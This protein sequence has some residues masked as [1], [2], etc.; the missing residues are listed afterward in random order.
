MNNQLIAE[1]LRDCL[2]YFFISFAAS[3][4]FAPIMIE[5]LY[6]FN[7]VRILKKT[8]LVSGESNELYMKIDHSEERNGTPNMGGILIWLIVPAIIA[9]TMDLSPL[10]RV[11]II[12]FLLFGFWGFLDVFFT[13]TLRNNEK[14]RAMQESFEWRMGKLLLTIGL[15]VL[16]MI[17]LKN[18]GLF[19][20][21]SFGSF[22]TI[23]V[24]PI[25]IG[26]LSIISQFAIYT[27]E[28]TDGIDGL[29]IGI[30]MIMYSV[31]AIMLLV[32]G[33]YLFIPV[34]AIILG[35]LAVDLYFNIP[36]ARFWNGGPGAMPLG[37]ALFFIALVTNN[38]IPYFFIAS[39]T[40]VIMF[41]SLL[42]IVSIRLFK[43]KIFKIAPLHH[44]FQAVGWPDYK[45][46]MRFWLY[47]F[48]S[49]MLG[50]FISLVI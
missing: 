2:K 13:N 27:S 5:L 32:Q 21:I 28:L 47:T 38:I 11:F 18:T 36:P 9:F 40:W 44:H 30:C 17:L 7:Q 34:I 19:G 16:V 37:F 1:L 35:T 42:Q 8:K 43:K 41:S 22:L 48:V 50:L 6:R 26:I 15:N 45:V 31:F 39:V 33:Q 4:L 46:T 20:E 25:V 14:L 10:I 29:L 3:A 24:S 23:S 49:S 12:A